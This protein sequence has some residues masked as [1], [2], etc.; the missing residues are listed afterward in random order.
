MCGLR[1]SERV[2][3]WQGLWTSKPRRVT[4]TAVGGPTGPLLGDGEVGILYDWTNATIFGYVGANSFWVYNK[5]TYGVTHR[6]AQRGLGWLSLGVLGS[7][8]GA[9]YLFK[10]IPMGG[11]VNFELVASN[12]TSQM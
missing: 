6:S 7:T 10:Q 12:Q 4:Q 9:R 11:S 8:P 2:G 1:G 3:C 5:D